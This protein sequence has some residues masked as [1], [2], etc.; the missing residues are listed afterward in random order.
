[1]ADIKNNTQ[2]EFLLSEYEQMFTE[3][4]HTDGRFM[5][6]VSLYFTII[7]ISVSVFAAVYKPEGEQD[8]STVFIF[9][10]VFMLVALFG[11]IIFSAMCFNRVNNV[12]A[13]RQINHIRKQYLDSFPDE[14]RPFIR[15]YIMIIDANRPRYHMLDSTHLVFIY[16]IA[17]FSSISMGVSFY[18]YP[19]L[20]VLTGNLTDTMPAIAIIL[21]FLIQY[22]LLRWKLI[23]KD[24]EQGI[25]S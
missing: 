11:M 23:K 25:G 12:R 15:N 20:Q 21:S 24:N 4:R 14:H 8:K 7:T 16:S 18:L 6:L 3:K 17:I 2:H 19:L 1:M 10:C 9:A 22:L 5:Y 13:I